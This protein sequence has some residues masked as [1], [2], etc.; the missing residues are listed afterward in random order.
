VLTTTGRGL[1]LLIAGAVLALTL[2]GTIWG[3]DDAFPFGPFRMNDDPA[4]STRI[5]GLTGDGRR[6]DIT[7]ETALRPAEIEGQLPRLRRHPELLAAFAEDYQRRHPGGRLNSV[8]IVAPE[9]GRR[10]VL[11]RWD[12]P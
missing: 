11:A 8:E 12:R 3:Q 9:H 10:A 5:D 1:R 6:L 7:G 4:R 2:V